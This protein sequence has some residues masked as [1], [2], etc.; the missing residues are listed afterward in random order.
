MRR[1]KASALPGGYVMRRRM[2]GANRV[3][4]NGSRKRC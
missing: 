2:E 3:R 1:V 4:D